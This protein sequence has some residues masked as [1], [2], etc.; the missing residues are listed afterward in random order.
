MSGFRKRRQRLRDARPG[1]GRRRPADRQA[2]GDRPRFSRT[3]ALASLEYE[4][5]D[6]EVRLSRYPD[7]QARRRAQRSPCPSRPATPGAAPAE[8]RR[9]ADR[10]RRR[11]VIKSPFVGTFYRSPSPDA[12]PFVEVGSDRR[13]QAGPVHRRGDEAHEPHRVRRPGRGPKRSSSRTVSRSNSVSRCSRSRSDREPPFKK[14]LVANRGE[15]ALRVIRAARELGIAHRR[16]L[17]RGRRGVDARQ[18]R[19]R[20]RVHRPPDP[21]ESYLHIPA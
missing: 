9:H 12:D 14:I 2:Q 18:V 8:R 19:G 20:V 21:A 10:G 17:L 5:E 11:H 3:P 13:A 15:I 1:S 7:G 6:I 4:D 16:R